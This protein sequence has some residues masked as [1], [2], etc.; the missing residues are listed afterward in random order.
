MKLLVYSLAIFGSILFSATAQSVRKDSGESG[1]PKIYLDYVKGGPFDRECGEAL[2]KPVKR[3]DMDELN[4]RLAEFQAIWDKDGNDYLQ[5][6]IKEI[7]RPFPF[8]EV[9][10]TLTAC[11]FSSMSSP[12]LIYTKSFLSSAPKPHPV[13]VFPI[14]IFH[15]LMHIYLR[16]LHDSSWHSKFSSESAR[17]LN[18]A[19][20]MALEKFV[21]ERSGKTTVLQWLD[22]RYRTRLTPDHKRAWELIN[23]EGYNVFIEEIKKAAS[24]K[25]S[26]K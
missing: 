7:G 20:I 8:R 6:V 4:N 19:Y 25:R 13:S 3:E 17:T 16:N 26:F 1:L 15:E 5:I 14:V 21:T 23:N 12:F 11:E 10:A 18:Q 24:K 22:I 9:H 2:S